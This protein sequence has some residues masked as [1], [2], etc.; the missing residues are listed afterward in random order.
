MPAPASA[1]LA[2]WNDADPARDA[3]YEAWH[4][5]EHVPERVANPGFVAGRRYRAAERVTQRYFTLYTLASL[6]AL[7]TARYAEVVERPT[8]WSQRM[9]PALRDLRR[10]A[11]DVVASAGRG[12]GGAMATL[13]LDADPASFDVP[14]M[15]RELAERADRDGIVAISF[16]AA[17]TTSPFPLAAALRTQPAGGP[18][19]VLLVE[20]LDRPRADACLAAL[21]AHFGRSGASALCVS[22]DLVFE[23]ERGDL[24]GADE[25]RPAPRDDLRMRW[26]PA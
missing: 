4:T 25:A 5:F 22:Y 3:E 2:L 1:F 23:V 13:V 7:R 21:E 18:Q 24:A 8:A 12:R 10:C 17:D 26:V 19:C 6:D 20:A 9:R 16:G 14:A 11:C 15:A